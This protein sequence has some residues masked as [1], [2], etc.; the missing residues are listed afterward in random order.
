MNRRTDPTLYQQ[1]QCHPH[2]LLKRKPI[3]TGPQTLVFLVETEALNHFAILAFAIG[4]ALN[5]NIVKI[6]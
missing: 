3:S 5:S 1:T 4:S 2:W 6:G